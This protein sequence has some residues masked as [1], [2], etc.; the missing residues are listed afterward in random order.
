MVPNLRVEPYNVQ[1]ELY[2]TIYGIWTPP[3]HFSPPFGLASLHPLWGTRY[4]PSST[5]THML[6]N[7]L[8]GSCLCDWRRG[9]S[10]KLTKWR[11]NKNHKLWG[12]NLFFYSNKDVYNN[13]NNNNNTVYNIIRNFYAVLRFPK[14][15][16]INIL[17]QKVASTSSSSLTTLRQTASVTRP[18]INP[19]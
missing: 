5:H 10:F 19:S 17:K 12:R 13:N 8:I 9:R 11:K 6:V 3:P 16:P 1:K 2:I 18:W 4:L 14:M 7:P 15:E